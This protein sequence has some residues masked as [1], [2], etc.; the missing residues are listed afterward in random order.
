ME[1]PLHRLDHW[2][3]AWS[4]NPPKATLVERG[5]VPSLPT[6]GFLSI[7]CCASC[8]PPM[9]SG[10]TK[11]PKSCDSRLSGILPHTGPYLWWVD[12]SERKVRLLLRSPETD[13]LGE[14]LSTSQHGEKVLPLAATTPQSAPPRP[15]L[16]WDPQETP[17]PASRTLPLRYT[18]RPG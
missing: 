13:H 14:V 4:R 1:L 5:L 12:L 11:S 17:R 18:E 3:L 6:P 9:A 15:G 8:L 7:L 2:D 10:C 16:P